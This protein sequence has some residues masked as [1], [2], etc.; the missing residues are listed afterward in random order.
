MTPTKTARL[1]ISASE[2]DS[3]LYYACHFLVP[4]PIIYFEVGNKKHMVLS[5]LEIDRAK[6]TASV[7]KIH[8][9]SD[10]AKKIKRDQKT[11]TIPAYA[12]ITQSLFCKLGVTHIEVP[13]NF[14]SEYFVA[15]KKLGYPITV[16]PDPFFEQR[17][18]KSIEEKNYIHETAV[19]VDSALKKALLLL[20][21]SKISGKKIFYGKELVTSELLRQVINTDLMHNGSVAFHTIVASGI[22]G[23]YPH[24][25]GHGP[26][27]PHTPI[28]F[29]IFPRNSHNQYWGDQTRT[30]LKGKATPTVKKMF[31][32]VIESNKQASAAV[33][34]GVTGAAVHAIASQVLEK[35]GFKTGKMGGRM[36][37]YIHSTG[38]GLGLDIHEAP[39]VSA[40]GGV[41]KTGMVVTIEPGLYYEKH[42][43]IRIEDDLYVLDKGA[44]VLTVSPKYLE[45]DR[46]H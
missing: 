36:Q 34:N 14:P 9:L 27:I 12:L 6:L 26:I 8:S 46:G 21:K 5:D 16:K 22:Q 10:V 17:L 43:G 44:E 35:H 40:K 42:G 18:I 7:H 4:D 24:H 1:I 45:I 15:F 20:E 39:S 13:A 37:G 25:E 32:A 2:S 23:S 19:H 3:N 33:T 11:K 29:D 31:D 28:I 30:F 38:H 41:L